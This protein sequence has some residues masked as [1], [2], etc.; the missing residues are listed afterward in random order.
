[1][2]V[3]HACKKCRLFLLIYDN[4]D[5]DDDED[6]DDGGG[7]RRTTDDMCNDLMC[8]QKLTRSQLSL[9]HSAKVKTY[10]MPDKSEKQLEAVK[11]V[12]WMERYKNYG[13]KD[14]RKR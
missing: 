2:A 1:M 12:R 13:G 10:M 14:L 6:D 3:A 9:A 4:D 11:S 5:D 7:G 8:T